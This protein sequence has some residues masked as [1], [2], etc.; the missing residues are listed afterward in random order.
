MAQMTNDHYREVISKM[1]KQSDMWL[2]RTYCALFLLAGREEDVANYL[3]N[4]LAW[5]KAEIEKLKT[6]VQQ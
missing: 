2:H 3:P 5:V 6:E 4:D 1:M